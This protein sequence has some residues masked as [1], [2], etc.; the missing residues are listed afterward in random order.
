MG[1]CYYTMLAIYIMKCHIRWQ[2]MIW[3]PIVWAL[4]HICSWLDIAVVYK[5]TIQSTRVWRVKQIRQW[6]R[7]RKL[8][9]IPK[10]D[11]CPPR[12]RSPSVLCLRCNVQQKAHIQ[13]QGIQNCGPQIRSQ[14]M[15]QEIPELQNLAMWYNGNGKF[16]W[17]LKSKAESI[18]CMINSAILQGYL[19]C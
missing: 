19:C 7:R 17:S 12:K 9:I 8:N 6:N 3:K 10:P 13:D 1:I 14:G 2:D 11:R 5:V 4:H 15:S 16:L 18:W